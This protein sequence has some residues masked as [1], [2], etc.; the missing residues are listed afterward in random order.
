M[1]S[2]PSS[3]AGDGSVDYIYS[4]ALLF[5]LPFRV[6]FPDYPCPIDLIVSVLPTSALSQDEC[7]NGRLDLIV[8]LS[9]YSD[10]NMRNHISDDMPSDGDQSQLLIETLTTLLTLG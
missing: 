10:Y 3:W 1:K 6:I 4:W 7:V 8:A 5:R 2:D 9:T